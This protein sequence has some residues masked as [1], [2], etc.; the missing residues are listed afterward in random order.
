MNAD[1][2]A[3]HFGISDAVIDEVEMAV[4]APGGGQQARSSLVVPDFRWM[5]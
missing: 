1:T 3:R 2:E 4:A 5:P